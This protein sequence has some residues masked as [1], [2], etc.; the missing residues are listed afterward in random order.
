MYQ[1]A[2]DS[3]ENHSSD[4]EFRAFPSRPNAQPKLE[5]PIYP[6]I[7]LFTHGKKITRLILFYMVLAV[8]EKCKELRPGFELRSLYPFPKT[9]NNT[10][11]MPT[12]NNIYPCV[13]VCVCV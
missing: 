1:C 10:P 7:L 3:S 6:G 8:Y 11:R 12:Y 13:C 9:V 5:S 4:F 2:T